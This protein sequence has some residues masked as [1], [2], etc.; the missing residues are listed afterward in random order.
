MPKSCLLASH[1]N[2]S[3]FTVLHRLTS[4]A[5]TRAARIAWQAI[6]LAARVVATS[7]HSRRINQ[8]RSTSP[9]IVVVAVVALVAASTRQ[10]SLI[11]IPLIN[12]QAR[13]VNSLINSRVRSIS[14][15]WRPRR[16]YRRPVRCRRRVSTTL[17]KYKVE[18]GRLIRMA[19]R[20]TR[21]TS[22][23]RLTIIF[24]VT[25]AD[26]RRPQWGPHWRALLP[27]HLHHRPRPY[28][29]TTA[30]AATA[31]TRRPT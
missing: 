4:T 20:Q 14:S 15:T 16:S 7:M 2:P 30:P 12:T 25:A 5:S 23:L 27:P 29:I 11:Q 17:V 18:M 10:A 26:L 21:L 8:A 31:P 28:P 13:R 1:R 19:R 24:P 22:M 9:S 6:I 3:P